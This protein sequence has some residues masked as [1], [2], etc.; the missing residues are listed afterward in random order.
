[1][2]DTSKETPGQKITRLERELTAART[3]L[4]QIADS[5]ELLREMVFG[6][7]QRIDIAVRTLEQVGQTKFV[8]NGLYGQPHQ[9]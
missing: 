2:T 6:T 5:F 8:E 1:M 4:R 3:E 7:K 9:V